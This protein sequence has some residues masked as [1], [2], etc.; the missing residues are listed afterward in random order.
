MQSVIAFIASATQGTQHR[1]TDQL[2]SW[3]DI[4]TTFVVRPF[5]S[6]PYG[7]QGGLLGYTDQ[8]GPKKLQASEQKL[9]A[10]VLPLLIDAMDGSYRSHAVI[11]FGRCVEHYGPG[12]GTI[13]RSGGSVRAP[14]ASAGGRERTV[15]VSTMPYVQV[16][17]IGHAAHPR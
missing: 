15:K 14:G 7:N 11:A 13:Y 12:A 9:I 4:A 5:V 17:I 10:T 16:C 1:L 3:Y 2:N 6:P 8:A